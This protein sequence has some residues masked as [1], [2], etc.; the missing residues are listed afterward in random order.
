MFGE[1]GGWLVVLE[2]DLKKTLE[3]YCSSR[4]SVSTIIILL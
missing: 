1:L 2:L 3:A 4:G